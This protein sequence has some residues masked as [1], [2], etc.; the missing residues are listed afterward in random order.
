MKELHTSNMDNGEHS[1]REASCIEEIA[2]KDFAKVP[3][4]ISS[5]MDFS[6]RLVKTPIPSTTKT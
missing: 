4:T 6:K 1:I 2:S 5:F 3:R